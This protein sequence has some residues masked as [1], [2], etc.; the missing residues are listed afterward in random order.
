MPSSPRSLTE[1]SISR[2]LLLFAVPILLGNVLQSL[3]GSVNSVWIGRYLGVAA[4]TASSNA[5]IVLFLLL[6]AL[7]GGSIAATILIGQYVGARRL[8]DAKRVVGTS[9]AFSVVVAVAVALLGFALCEPLLRATRTPLLALPLAIAYMRVI[10]L[11]MPFMV[12]YI[13][14]TSA[15]RGAGDSKT[16]LLFLLLSV[17]LDIGLNPVFIFGI[18][19][20]PRLGIAGSALATLLA[21]AISLIALIWYLYRRKDPL[22]LYGEE[23]KLLHVDWSIVGTLISKGVPMA[24]Q[25]IVLSLSM[26]LMISLVNGFGIDTAAAYGAA[27]QVWNYVQMPSF[28]IG[29]AV[30][31]MAAQNIGAQKWDRVAATARVGVLYQLLLTGSLVLIIQLLARVALGLFLPPDSGAL[32][33]AEHLNRIAAWSF[34]FFG[35]SMVLFGVVRANGAVMA[36]LIILVVSLLGIRFPLAWSLIGRWHAD[37]IWWS[38]PLSSAV[39]VILAMVYYNSGGWRAA[40]MMQPAGAG[41][42]TEGQMG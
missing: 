13:F 42:A 39:A 27:Q 37:A 33:I 26:V 9:I 15:L 17:G 21:Q 18:G 10:F 2:R 6:G 12:L 7:F 28:A 11:A 24:L 32:H 31:S 34:V 41:G 38:F 1:G 8:H 36:P 14:A 5:N 16:P 20:A 40:R 30:S 22:C 23:L 19:P 29:M 35:I 4:L 25:M 3:N